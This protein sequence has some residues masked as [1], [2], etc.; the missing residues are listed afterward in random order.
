MLDDQVCAVCDDVVRCDLLTRNKIF[1]IKTFLCPL[2]FAFKQ[3]SEHHIVRPWMRNRVS[4]FI[5]LAHVNEWINH[6]SII[7]ESIRRKKEVFKSWT[8][9]TTSPIV[10]HFSIYLQP[11]HQSPDLLKR[12]IIIVLLVYYQMFVQYE[13]YC[14]ACTSFQPLLRIRCT[15]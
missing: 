1:V 4:R 2:E 8:R 6:Q 15:A 3:R 14:F 10:Y 5:S 12:K 11:L 9:S 7:G 13:W